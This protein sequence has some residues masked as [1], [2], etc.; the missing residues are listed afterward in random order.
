VNLIGGS[1]GQSTDFSFNS[2]F[3]VHNSISLAGYGYFPPIMYQAL[4]NK[5]N[6]D[7]NP[8]DDSRLLPSEEKNNFKIIYYFLLALLAFL[9]V[10]L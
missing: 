3:N 7:I 10:V 8:V 2:M 1:D 4:T 5:C 9:L 6:L